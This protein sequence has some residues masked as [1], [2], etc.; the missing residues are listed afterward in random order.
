MAIDPDKDYH[1]YR[2][3]NDG[4]WSDKRG[5]NKVRIGIKILRLMHIK[6]NMIFLLKKKGL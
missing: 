3:N 5:P 6:C 1:F 4:T 2:M